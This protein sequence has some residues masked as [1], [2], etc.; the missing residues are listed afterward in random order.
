[1]ELLWIW[2]VCLKTNTLATF[3]SGGNPD[4]EQIRRSDFPFSALQ[5]LKKTCLYLSRNALG[6][7][8]FA[9]GLFALT[10]DPVLIEWSEILGKVLQLMHC[11]HYANFS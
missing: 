10:P 4:T 1:M 9:S 2:I 5:I 8:G 7:P 6:S 11:Y 3:V